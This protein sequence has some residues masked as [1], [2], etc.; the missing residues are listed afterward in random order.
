MKIKI[1]ILSLS[2]AGCAVSVPKMNEPSF[3]RSG[4][5]S[6]Y[7]FVVIEQG[8]TMRASIAQADESRAAA[9]SREFNPTQL[10]EG[11]FLKKG[12][13][14]VTS[15]PDSSRNNTLIAK[16]GVSGSRD[17]VIGNAWKGYARA[18]SQE[19]TI[20][21]ISAT[22]LRP[23]FSCTG[24]GMGVTELDDIRQAIVSCLSGL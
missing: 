10:M 14:R 9:Q 1:A 7:S 19:V 2:I 15:V 3:A 6:A 23:V 5:V 20:S 11:V 4:D 22:D 17:F 13:V 18:Y 21:L 8:P 12:L 16:W 24:E